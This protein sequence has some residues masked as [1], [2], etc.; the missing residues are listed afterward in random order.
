MN[1][2]SLKCLVSSIPIHPLENLQCIL[3]TPYDK[4][5]IFQDIIDRTFH[6]VGIGSVRNLA[7]YYQ[8]N[9][10]NKRTKKLK[11]CEE[12]LISFE[13]SVQKLREEKKQNILQLNLQE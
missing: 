2:Y 13:D 9:V 8:E 11:S 6:E 1:Y 12:E 7:A 5:I 10:L 4:E 3:E